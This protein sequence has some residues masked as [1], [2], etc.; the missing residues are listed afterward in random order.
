MISY[1]SKESAVVIV[2]M[3]THDEKLH[4]KRVLGYPQATFSYLEA[5]IVD[6]A[7]MRELKGRDHV[8]EEERLVLVDL[9]EA[10]NN[11]YHRHI[12]LMGLFCAT[13]LHLRSFLHGDGI[14]VWEELE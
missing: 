12:P 2:G 8:S 3:L 5:K 9:S 1:F 4:L 14:Q 7:V 6:K 11:E 10:L 13:G